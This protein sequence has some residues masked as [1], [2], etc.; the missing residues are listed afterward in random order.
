MHVFGQEDTDEDEEEKKQNTKQRENMQKLTVNA[1]YHLLR[2]SNYQKCKKKKNN[3]LWTIQ[4]KRE[5]PEVL[6]ECRS[7]LEPLIVWAVLLR[8]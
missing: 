2:T 5:R 1:A 7:P 4:Y 8:Q 6:R 3:C